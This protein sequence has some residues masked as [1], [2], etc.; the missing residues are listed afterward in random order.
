MY[1]A[2]T[3]V[4]EGIFGSLAVFLFKNPSLMHKFYLKPINCLTT[5]SPKLEEEEP[6]LI[7]STA[8][9]FDLKLLV[10]CAAAQFILLAVPLGGTPNGLCWRQNAINTRI[11]FVHKIGQPQRQLYPISVKGGVRWLLIAPERC[12]FE[13]SWKGQWSMQRRDQ[14]LSCWCSPRAWRHSS[15]RS[16]DSSNAFW[17]LRSGCW[18]W[19]IL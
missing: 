17:Y 14:W 12:C 4:K 16:E 1:E 8:T 10:K 19:K 9:Q 7:S 18:W 2:S 11:V 3:D 13:K 6:H 15:L 5:V